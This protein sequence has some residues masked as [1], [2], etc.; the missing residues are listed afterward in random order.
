[1][2][3]EMDKY[4]EKAL[5]NKDVIRV[6]NVLANSIREDPADVR[7]IIDFNKRKIEQKAKSAGLEL[8]Q[9][10]DGRTF[11]EKSEWNEEYLS[12][13]MAQLMSSNFSKK[14]FN[15]ILEVGREVYKD[16]L[17]NEVKKRKKK[18][19]KTRKPITTNARN[20]TDIKKLIIIAI[21]VG[22]IILI[23]RVFL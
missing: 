7:G 4:L 14:R 5:E 19:S 10:H 18:K 3:S 17:N 22:A 9:E 6:R 8:W 20:E 12:L 23:I 1:M 2:S 11:K 15:H 13:L 16:E 21:G